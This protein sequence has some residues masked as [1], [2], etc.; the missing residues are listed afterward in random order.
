MRRYAVV[1]APVRHS[2]SPWIHAYFARTTQRPIVYAA[3]APAASFDKLAE[4]FF[5]GGGGGLNITVPFKRAALGFAG[6]ASTFAR[7]ADAANVLMPDKQSGVINAYNTDGAGFIK[8]IKRCYGA[9]LTGKRV[10]I[11]GAGG[12]ARAAVTMLAD[13]GA[14]L[15]IAARRPQQAAA[16]AA[17][18]S[19]EA[20]ALDTCG[21]G[22]D[23]VINAT[24]GGLGGGESPLPAAAFAG[25]VLAYDLNYGKAAAAFLGAATAARKR[26]DGSGMLVEQAALSFALWEGVLPV[27]AELINHLRVRNRQLWAAS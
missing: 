24:S 18:V 1:G 21:D 10:L 20:T 4:D 11:V 12:A 6:R 5:A 15:L 9:S 14:Q 26:A 3:Y 13:E 23:I 16:L 7:R 2:L 22:F 17:A 19:G 8:D 25:A 27:T